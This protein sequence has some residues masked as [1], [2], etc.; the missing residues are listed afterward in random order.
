MRFI[1]KAAMTAGP[2]AL[3]AGLLLPADASAATSWSFDE[4]YGSSSGKMSLFEVSGRVKDKD[5]DGLCV[6]VE[7]TWTLRSGTEVWD[8]SP[9]ACPQGDI[10]LF[11]VHPGPEDNPLSAKAVK[12]KMVWM[13][14]SS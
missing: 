14:A 4:N 2:V 8:N 13:P 5:D 11:K 7:I 1:S 9:K 6:R 10:D 3:L 12:V